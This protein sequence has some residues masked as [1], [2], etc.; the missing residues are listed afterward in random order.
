M[1]VLPEDAARDALM[2]PFASGVLARTPGALY[3]GARAGATL[4][5]AQWPGLVCEQGVRPDAQALQEVGLATHA[6]VPDGPAWPQVLLLPPRQRDAARALYARALALAD[7]GALVVASV[8]NAEGARSAQADF[9]RV[10]GPVSHLVKH[11][12]RVFWA[13]KGAGADAALAQQWRQADA[14]REVAPGW[15]SRPGVFAWD[16]VD[17]GSALLIAH[18]PETLAGEVADLGAGTGVLADALLRRCAQVRALDLYEAQ[19]EALALARRNL[20]P[21][22]DRLTPGFH[23]HDVTAGLP[24]RYDAIITNPPFHA[25]GHASLPALG[26]AF[27]RA[28]AGALRPGGWLWLVAN[29]QLPYE[30]VLG[31]AFTQISTVAQGNGF[32]VI[33]ARRAS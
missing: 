18:L 25:Q 5:A 16:R 8:A 19:F 27:I 15:W 29:R 4:D 1:P 17:A 24:R 28:A 14:P 11:K 10:A 12:C 2:F 32:K 13:R 9:A 3:L 20:A 22:A 30:G 33:S 26:Q 23:W 6:R 7:T 31:E 21:H